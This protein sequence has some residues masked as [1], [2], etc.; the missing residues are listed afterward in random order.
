MNGEV[1]VVK[2]GELTKE[3]VALRPASESMRAVMEASTDSGSNS[4]ISIRS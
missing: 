1:Q 2:H 4:G 3:V